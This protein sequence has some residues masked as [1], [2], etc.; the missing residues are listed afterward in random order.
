MRLLVL[1]LLAFA[2]ADTAAQVPQQASR[3]RPELTRAS[4]VVW[5]IEAPIPAFAA[6]I[7]QESAWRPEVCSPYACGLTQFTPDT[8]DWINTVYGTELGP[9]D[10]FNPVWAIR[11][12]VR[13]DK[14][15][16]DATPGHTQCDR[17]WGAL[18]KYNG[19][20]G[21]WNMESRY[22]EDRLD[23]SSVDPQCG[24]ARRSVKHC[25]E[26]LGYPRRILLQHQPKYALW[27]SVVT[28]N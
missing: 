28:C 16:Y 18:R 14:H 11:A 13:Y 20:A 9:K 27:G 15:L 17:M 4:R 5:G 3:Y 8:A 25:P 6:Q 23:R 22:A 2:A 24:K 21:H 26:S 19:G 12:L 1:C 7:H 10:R